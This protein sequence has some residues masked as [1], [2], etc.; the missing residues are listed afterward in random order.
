[1]PLSFALDVCR[2]SRVGVDH[3]EFVVCPFLNPVSFFESRCIITDQVPV[4]SLAIHIYIMITVSRII[5]V[6]NQ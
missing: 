2:V 4:A 1:L 5:I 6:F 3:L